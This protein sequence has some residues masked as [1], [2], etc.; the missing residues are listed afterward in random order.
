MVHKY[1]N[2]ELNRS[3]VEHEQN[4]PEMHLVSEVL[5]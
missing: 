1:Q 4:M 3:D 2:N 5:N